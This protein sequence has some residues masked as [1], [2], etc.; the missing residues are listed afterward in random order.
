MRSPYRRGLTVL[1]EL[2]RWGNSSNDP[3]ELSQDE[4]IFVHMFETHSQWV[5]STHITPADRNADLAT[6]LATGLATDRAR[7]RPTENLLRRLSSL[8]NDELVGESQRIGSLLSSA[9]AELGLVLAEIEARELHKDFDCGTVERYASWQCQLSPSNARNTAALGRAVHELPVL[10]D[11]LV[12]GRLSA[13][14][15]VMIAKVAAPDSEAALVDLSQYTSMGQLQ[16]VCNSWRAVANRSET[17]APEDLESFSTGRVVVFHDDHGIELRASFDHSHGALVLSALDAVT[18]HV[19]AEHQN[20]AVSHG[21]SHGVS[22]AGGL[23]AV[24]N[25][26]A[27]ERLTREQWRAEGFVRMCELANGFVP[28]ELQASGFSTQ[29]VVH[30]PVDTL[31]H[32]TPLSDVHPGAADV[33]EPAG[34]VLRREAARWLACDA[35]L[36]TVLEDNNGDPLHLGRRTSAI[37]PHLRRAV[38]ARYRTCTWPG[39]TSTIV[40]LHHRHH[41]SVGGHDDLENLV[42]LC[43]FHHGVVHRRGITVAR[44]ACGELRFWRPD[45]SEVSAAADP[46]PPGAPP[47]AP[48]GEASNALEQ[49]HHDCGIN[50]SDRRRLPQWMNDPFHLGDIIEALQARRDAA[51]RRTHPTGSVT[52]GSVTIHSADHRA[53]HRADSN[54]SRK[55]SST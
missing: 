31:L 32:P 38:H 1:T 35:G 43:R 33:L 54:R 5:P 25:E 29:V 53:D 14:K 19:R 46:Q 9:R 42:P 18:A 51:R 13:D 48:A 41:R 10:G 39:C 45:G 15:A 47:P 11:A 23:P 34:V 17:P 40:Q 3:W 55:N 28:G 24:V 7:S 36:Q 52:H 4:R 20:A 21:V 26:M 8:S 27:I 6:D 44:D 37:T 49:Q 16:K 12:E 22:Q 2:G 50:T 30:V